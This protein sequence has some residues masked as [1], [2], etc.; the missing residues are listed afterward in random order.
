MARGVK[1]LNLCRDP[2]DVG[3]AKFLS[4]AIP[5]SYVDTPESTFSLIS[6]NPS[7]GPSR[8][9][10]S[11]CTSLI[12]LDFDVTSEPISLGFNYLYS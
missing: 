2:V 3:F 1:I 10:L 11:S 8:F 6:L 5:S 4:M 9:S 12:S 7:I